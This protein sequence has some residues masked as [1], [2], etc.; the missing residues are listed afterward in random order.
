MWPNTK[1]QTRSSFFIVLQMSPVFTSM[2]PLPDS[3]ILP[4]TFCPNVSI[5]H[6]SPRWEGQRVHRKLRGRV[7]APSDSRSGLTEVA[8]V[9]LSFFSLLPVKRSFC[10]KLSG[11][12]WIEKLGTESVFFIKEHI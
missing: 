11:V 8:S 7:V 3:I 6:L 5:R 9:S 1:D 4:P 10:S 2:A 12:H